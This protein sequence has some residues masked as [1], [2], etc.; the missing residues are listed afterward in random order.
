MRRRFGK[1]TLRLVGWRT[2]GQLPP[3]PKFVIIGAPHTSNWD[4]PL[5]LLAAAALGV[6]ISWIG[7]DALFRWPF[8]GL[9]RRLGGIPVRRDSREGVVQRTAEAFAAATSL[10]LVVAPE[11]TRGRTPYWRSGFYHIAV[12][13]GVP[14]VPAYIDRPTKQIG[15]GAPL[16]PTGE[17]RRDMEALRGFY[18][19]KVGI[20]P[21]HAGDVRLREE[22]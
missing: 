20:R 2:V 6:K 4:F 9:M 5:A 18:A 10:M 7:K 22:D 14:I 17:V 21:D 13:A 15:I 3:D 12:A 19:G 11:G 16:F 8:G 1:W